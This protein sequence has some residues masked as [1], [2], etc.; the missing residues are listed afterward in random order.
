[1]NSQDTSKFNEAIALVKDADIAVLVLGNDRTVEHEGL[2][3]VDTVLSG[4][5]EEFAKQILSL[6]K[7]TLLIMSNGGMLAIDDLIE[8][9][10]GIVETFN[11]AQSTRQLASLLFGDTNRWG[12]LPVTMYPASFAKQKSMID[13]DMSSGVGR[14]YKYYNGKPLY[15]FGYGL[16]LTTFDLS[17]CHAASS[18]FPLDVECVVENTGSMEGDEVVQVYHSAGDDIRTKIQDKHPAPIRSLVDFERV[19]ISSGDKMSVKFT[20]EEDSALMVNEKGERVMYSGTHHFVF[21]TGVIEKSLQI[22]V[23][24]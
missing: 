13:Y 20:I 21:S 23:V 11:P 1:M 19:T 6:G 22:T 3:R 8:P 16:S 7:P 5:Q 15:P 14:T 2:D 18:T 9:L 17:A 12:K 4:V 10:D 24:V